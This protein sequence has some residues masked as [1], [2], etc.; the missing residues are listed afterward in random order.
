MITD[1]D[2]R[3]NYDFVLAFEALR[4]RHGFREMSDAALHEIAAS[5]GVP[6]ESIRIWR[7]LRNALAHGDRVNR[8]QLA[9]QLVLIQQLAE[10][11]RNPAGRG[12]LPGDGTRPTE[13]ASPSIP[14]QQESNRQAFRIH[15]WTD[16][17][18]EQEMIANGFISI[19][20]DE[21]DDLTQVHDREVIRDTLIRTMPDRP[22]RAIALFVGYWT[23]FLWEA[24]PGDLIVLPLRDRSVAIGELTG[25]YHYVA[26]RDAR[27]QHRRSVAWT[28]FPARH[29]FNAELTKVLNSQHTVQEFK[30]THAVPELEDL[31]AVDQSA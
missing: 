8:D 22:A 21:I 7:H 1:S 30:S 3:L 4:N 6:Y 14:A 16:D 23:R 29:A 2:L 24:K 13:P 18:L 31:M 15:A 20:G 5:S 28:A 12:A 11:H 9:E 27:A 19:G 26:A 17:R 10:T 25:P